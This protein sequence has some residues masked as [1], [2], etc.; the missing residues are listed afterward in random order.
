MY[1]QVYILNMQDI[2]IRI[3]SQK[4]ATTTKV[5]YCVTTNNIW[6]MYDEIIK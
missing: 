2:L 5:Y 3:L 4:G 1:N 6:S